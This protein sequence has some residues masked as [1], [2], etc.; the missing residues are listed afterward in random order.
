MIRAAIALAAAIAT[1]GTPTPPPRPDPIRIDR[2]HVSYLGNPHGFSLGETV[3]PVR[4][5]FTNV[6]N[7]PVSAVTFTI[8]LGSKRASVRDTG[9]FSP[10]VSIE[11]LYDAFRGT[12]V[13]PSHEPQPLCAVRSVEF[14]DG[15][16]LQIS[17]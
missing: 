2:C 8:A 15:S 10:H 17:R 4:I 14:A 13:G 9:T 5:N 1:A 6:G 12:E 16:V 3:G 11:H 7:A